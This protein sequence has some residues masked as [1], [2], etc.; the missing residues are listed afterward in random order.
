MDLSSVSREFPYM[1]TK[2]LIIPQSHAI[3]VSTTGGTPTL[4]ESGIVGRAQ[5]IVYMAMQN[6]VFVL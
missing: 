3:H 2:E 1:P 5:Q 4:T 6:T